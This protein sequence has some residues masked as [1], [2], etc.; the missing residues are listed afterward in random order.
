M[1]FFSLVCFSPTRPFQKL[2][3]IYITCS[4]LHPK[5]CQNPSTGWWES[6]PMG[7]SCQRQKGKADFTSHFAAEVWNTY[8]CLEGVIRSP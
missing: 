8:F 2:T 4:P 5:W 6:V 1:G 7:R 3:L